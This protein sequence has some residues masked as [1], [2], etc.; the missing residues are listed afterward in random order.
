MRILLGIL[1][2]NKNYCAGLF[3]ML[4]MITQIYGHSVA[5]V[6]WT[7]ISTFGL[8][9]SHNTSF[10]SSFDINSSF[11]AFNAGLGYKNFEG[12]QLNNLSAYLGLGIGSAIQLQAGFSNAGFSL[13]NRYDMQLGI[14]F[15]EFAEKYP[16]LGLITLSVCIEK[17]F[18]SPRR[19]WY[20]GMGIGFSINNIHGTNVF[21]VGI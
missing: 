4:A 3:F 18:N 12:P 2:R 17:Y 11:A 5:P 13:R 16:Y 9:D 15:Y 14:L 1:R 6:A 10:L 21:K 8:F 19:N 7:T 20:F